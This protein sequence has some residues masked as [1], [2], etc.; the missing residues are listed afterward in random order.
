MVPFKVHLPSD[1]TFFGLTS[2]YKLHVADQIFDL[3]YHSKGAFT[4]TEI[5][6]MPVY[7][8]LYYMRRLNKLFE[9]QHKTQEKAMKE[10]K[11]K[12][13]ARSPKTNRR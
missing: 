2:K 10:M 5:Q 8:R 7:L 11:S 9:D 3:S 1:W 6:N 12:S 4:Y 13:R